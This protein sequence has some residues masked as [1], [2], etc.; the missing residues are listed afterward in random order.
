MKTYTTKLADI[1]RK[2]HKIDASG[3]VLGRLATR[4]ASLLIGKHKAA[5]ERHMDF[6]DF[7]VVTNAREVVVTGKKAEQ[8]M[9]YRHS[10]Y[11][12]GLKSINYARMMQTHPDRIIEHAVKG[13]LPQNK[14]RARML[15]RLKVYAGEVPVQAK[16]TP[17]GNA[18][19]KE[20]SA[21]G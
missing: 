7:V 2:S 15:K 20:D 10:Q 3:E 4:I 9:Y 18:V 12:G 11:P 6:G 5:F 1:K 17:A 8:K 13:M 14:L 19:E 21:N 16:V